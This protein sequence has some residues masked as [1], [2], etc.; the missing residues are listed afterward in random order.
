MFLLGMDAIT[1]NAEAV[2]RR[3]AEG[4]GKITVATAAELA[5]YTSAANFATAYR[6]VYGIAPSER[7]RRT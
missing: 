4:A 6:R 7:R 5:G 3:N 1:D 2:Q